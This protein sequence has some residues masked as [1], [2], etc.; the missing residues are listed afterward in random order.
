MQPSEF[1]KKWQAST[2]KESAAAQSHFHDLCDLI[3]LAKPA[4]ED[5][6]GSHYT[7]EKQAADEAAMNRTGL[8]PLRPLPVRPLPVHSPD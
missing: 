5:V 4:D 8:R 2:L 1:V 3:G 7:F 6:D